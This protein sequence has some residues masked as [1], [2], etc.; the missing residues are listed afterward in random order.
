ML[1]GLAFQIQRGSLHSLWLGLGLTALQPIAI[2]ALLAAIVAATVAV[3][4]DVELRGDLRRMAALF[5]GV[6][7]VAQIAANYWTWAYLPWALVP[8]LLSLLAPNV[9]AP[10]PASAVQERRE[11]PVDQLVPGQ[12]ANQ[13]A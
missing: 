13:P 1:D 11:V 9:V 12:Q 6:M 2:A 7:L 10:A 5:A 3:R 8:L 4:R